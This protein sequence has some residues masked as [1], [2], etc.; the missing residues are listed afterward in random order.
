MYHMP[1]IRCR[2]STTPREPCD[3]F[4]LR[5]KPG[6][7]PFLEPNIQQGTL[8]RGVLLPEAESSGAV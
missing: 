6:V 3:M 1:D 8:L 7:L 5:N 4:T 2:T